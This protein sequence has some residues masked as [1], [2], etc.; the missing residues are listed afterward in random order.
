MLPGYNV[1]EIDLSKKPV[2]YFTLITNKEEAVRFVDR[3]M[4]TNRIVQARYGK[5]ADIDEFFESVT[6]K[7]FI[8]VIIDVIKDVLQH[9]SCSYTKVLETLEGEYEKEQI[10]VSERAMASIIISCKILMTELQPKENLDI[11]EILSKLINEKKTA[12]VVSRETD[13]DSIYDSIFMDIFLYQY[14][15]QYYKDGKGCLVKMILDEAQSCRYDA[16]LFGMA[17]RRMNVSVDFIYQN[18]NQLRITHPYDW[19]TIV[20]NTMA[21][22]C[23]CAHDFETI[24]FMKGNRAIPSNV[25]VQTLPAE[26]ELILCPKL[27]ENW[28]VAQKC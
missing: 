25:D 21:I 3:V 26:Q 16:K 5:Y 20:K 15:K 27:Q 28:F 24:S 7:I 9:G 4:E 18:I 10:S 22:V 8:D 23:L 12:L 13:S 19:E 1:I 17:T 14:R 6:R 2:D 11:T